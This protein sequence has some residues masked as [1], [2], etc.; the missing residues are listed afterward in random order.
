MS[1]SIKQAYQKQSS[2][3]HQAVQDKL[4]ISHCNLIEPEETLKNS[5]QSLRPDNQAKFIELINHLID[6]EIQA[7]AQLIGLETEEL[8]AWIALQIQAPAKT[9]LALLRL[10]KQYELDP[11]QEE[12]LISQFENQWQASISIDGWIKLIHRDPTFAGMQFRESPQTEQDG[13]PQWLECT[14]YRSNRKIP[15][16]VREYFTEVTQDTEIWKKMPRRML[17][18]RTLQQCA[19]LALGIRH[20]D[21]G[22]ISQQRS[23]NDIGTELQ[24]KLNHKKPRDHLDTMQILKDRLQ[25]HPTPNRDGQGAI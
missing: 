11:L 19:R 13:P 23:V 3:P 9:I 12:V 20:Q 16:T 6:K 14:I 24:K 15:T 17:R 22:R 2:P 10:A 18:N 4:Q 7:C 1:R 25:Q 5:A 21:S 8:R